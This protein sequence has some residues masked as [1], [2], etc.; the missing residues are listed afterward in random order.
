ML[1][2]TRLNDLNYE[3]S[4]HF[5]SDVSEF[6]PA[7]AHLFRAA[8]DAGVS[9][10][11]VFQASPALS[12]KVIVD[13]PAVYVAQAKDLKQAQ[14]IHRSLWNLFY[15]PYIIILLPHQVRAYTGFKYSEEDPNEGFLD[16][17]S[18]DDLRLLLAEF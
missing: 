6:E 3:Q 17:F 7:T 10:I 4:P 2:S 1:L 11:Y 14:R 9:G 13:R 8:R 16:E 12:Q 5:R 18:L 15:A